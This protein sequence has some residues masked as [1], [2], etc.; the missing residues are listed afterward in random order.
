[1]EAA[2]DI[3]FFG[4]NILTVDEDDSK[5]EAL[6]VKDGKIVSVGTFAEVINRCAG[7]AT[8]R[9]ALE[10]SQTLLPGFIEAH[11]HAAQLA[12]VRV[13][14]TFISGGEFASY[15]AVKRTIIKTVRQAASA[16]PVKGAV[17]WGWDVE[18]IPDLPDLNADLIDSEF[19]QGLPAAVPVLIF[20]QSAHVGWVNNA[21]LDGSMMDLSNAPEQ[22][23]ERREGKLT[24]KI[25]HVDNIMRV[26]RRNPV[27]R[28]TLK[29]AVCDQWMDYASRGF[30]T[31]T[32]L[33]H[34]PSR[35]L[36]EVLLEVAR[37]DNC[38]L[39]VALYGNH[40]ALERSSKPAPSCCSVGIPKGGGDTSPLAHSFHDNRKLWYQGVKLFADGSPHCG[41]M[42]VESP[43]LT[44]DLTKKLGFPTK[45]HPR[46]QLH[47][48]D[49]ELL[50]LIKK[51]HERGDRPQIAIHTHGERAIDQVLALYQE[52]DPPE[53]ASDRRYRMEHL[54]LMTEAQIITAAE[55]H[56]AL[57]FF[58]C[59]LYYYGKTFSE[60]IFGRERTNRWSP[61]ALAEKHGL[62]W[63]I[64][65]DHPAF[66]GLPTPFIN[67]KA[68]VTRCQKDDPNTVY[69]KEH[70]VN[71][72]QAIKAYTTHAA[73]Q[74]HLEEYV[75]SLEV[76]KL[77]DLLVVDHNPYTMDPHSLDKI[78]VVETFLDG[79]PT[80]LAKLNRLPSGTYHLRA[81]LSASSQLWACFSD[82]WVLDFTKLNKNTHSMGC[83][84]SETQSRVELIL[85]HKHFS[86]SGT[87]FIFMSLKWF[88]I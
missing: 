43:F 83:I 42:A 16:N 41:T 4:G 18:L 8:K 85:L 11:T 49:K 84:V 55:Q 39:R 65:Q 1:M 29:R 79:K 21:A 48:E 12:L 74:L 86:L 71:I 33:K 77:A 30:T 7:P 31:V 66:P 58:V 78:K 15:D 76:G 82:G 64:H 10:E 75:G 47:Y 68:A 37:E 53:R 26:W 34:D 80:G 51:Y 32:D 57:S 20:G 70:C 63:T 24:G 14:F 19:C 69:G 87:T 27:D 72:K 44:N 88:L 50:S 13:S 5:A 40:V 36:D 28:D 25:L 60:F 23:F 22:Y 45:D 3:I 9:I 59:H 46:G 54:G 38:P 62:R 6:A 17:F 2:A 56:L 35:R 52:V 61:L 67:I 73:W 81:P